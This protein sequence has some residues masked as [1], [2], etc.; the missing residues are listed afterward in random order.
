MY[1]WIPASS[2]SGPLEHAEC[3][4]LYVWLLA[5]STQ[6]HHA[7]PPFLGPSL[8]PSPVRV[9]SIGLA[10]AVTVATVLERL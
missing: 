9:P 10:M 6:P 8:P 5:Q 1:K 4:P 7:F 2:C 3:Q